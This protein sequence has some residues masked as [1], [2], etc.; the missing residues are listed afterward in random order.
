MEK[1]DSQT[2]QINNLEI[3]NRVKS[4]PENA[5]KS[6]EAGRLKGKSDINPMWRIKKLTELFGPVGFG[7]YTEVLNRWEETCESGEVAVFVEISLYVKKDGEWSKPI[8]GT[9]GNK[10]VSMEKKWVNGAQTAV[11]Y[12]DDDS[13]KKA[14]TDAISVAAKA[15]GI[16]ADVYWNADK[17]KFNQPSEESPEEVGEEEAQQ[18]QSG[19]QNMY[20]KK[21]SLTPKNILYWRQAIAFTASQ[22]DDRA[23]L[24]KRIR[25][26]YEISD[27][28]LKNLMVQAGK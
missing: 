23:S 26:K 5:V 18:A 17:G 16:G 19:A 4:V 24:E 2:S 15:L 28:D 27:E 12:L 6:I 8:H 22:P 13:Y 11:A 1:N 20:A 3:Y 14:Y 10:V 21:P 25:S 9:G 7:W